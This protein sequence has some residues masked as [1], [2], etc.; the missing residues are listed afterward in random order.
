MSRSVPTGSYLYKNFK[1]I[2]DDWPV[3]KTKSRERNLR[4]LLE[5][6][7]ESAFPKS[8]DSDSISDDQRILSTENNVIECKRRLE[9]I[10]ICFQDIK[11][12]N[13]CTE[14]ISEEGAR[15]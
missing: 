2:I 1:R 7:L 13:P 11:W 8:S 3:D 4:F 10:H 15:S 5:K 14:R 12:G 6:K 9:G